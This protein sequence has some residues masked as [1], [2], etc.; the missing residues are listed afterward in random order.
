MATR[1][2]VGGT[3]TWDASTTTHW[4]AT[5]NGAG[6]ASVPGSADTVTFDGSSG[7]GTVTVNTTVNVISLTTSAFTGTLDFSVNNN[8]V[9]LSGSWANTG[10]GVRT[11]KLGAGI[12]AL[13]GGGNW[14]W[15]SASNLT[16]DAGTSAIV[17]SG[18]SAGSTQ[19]FNGGGFTYA[20]VEIGAITTAGS[21]HSI[22]QGNTF[23]TLKIDGP[24]N[25]TLNQS[26]TQTVTSLDINGS[27]SGLIEL[28]SANAGANATISV[29]SG[30]PTLSF[31][32]L[33]RITFTGGATF[34]ANSSFDM[35]GNSGI[36]INGPSGGS[37]A[38]PPV[39]AAA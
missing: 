1:F 13:S 29:A 17:M 25:V 23:G 11:I 36:T 2:W 31:A 39:R 32:A 15:N 10:S 4:A 7:G 33:S 26:V 14:S 37:A 12:F 38:F 22:S 9:T 30:A 27:S 35:L 3:G 24:N 21:A 18:A 20:T 19:S 16:F 28:A 6:G 5:S 34:A 8:N